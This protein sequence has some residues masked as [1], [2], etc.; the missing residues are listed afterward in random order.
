MTD[1]ELLELAAKAA[2]MPQPPKGQEVPQ[3][4]PVVFTENGKPWNPLR[5]KIIYMAKE[6]GFLE[7][8]GTLYTNH[9]YGDCFGELER[10]YRAA[11]A[12]GA[13]A[14]RERI[15]AA[16]AP[17]IESINRHIKTLEEAFDA[18]IRARGNV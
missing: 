17:V 13:A 10:F 16:N 5:D 11:F 18:A 9:K 3:D 14:E 4:L 7:H 8:E 2:G 6:V 15:V 1:R 12:A